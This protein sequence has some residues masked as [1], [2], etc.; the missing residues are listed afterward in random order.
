METSPETLDTFPNRIRPSLSG[1]MAQGL[2][3]IW[4]VGP[5]RYGGIIVGLM[6]VTAM[7]CPWLAPYDPLEQDIVH[8]FAGPSYT[9]WL[10]TDYLGRD[11]LS[12]LLYGCRIA[13]VVALGAS[14][15]SAVVGTL[16][17]VAA[18]YREGSKLDYCVIFI[19]D[20]IRSFPQIILALA[21]V[22]VMGSSLFNMIM[23]LGFTV[24]PFYGRI[25]RA[26][27]LSVK[28][29]DFIQAAEA[30][31]VG[32]LRII[33]RHI[34]PNILSPLLICMGM[35]MVNMII[36][37]SGLSFLGLGVIPPDASWGI[38]LSNGFKYI[39][40]SIWMILWPGAALALAMIGFSLFSEGMRTALDPKRRLRG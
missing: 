2:A 37:E 20:V 13:M 32:K 35:D 14:T 33:F 23:A 11:L 17:G 22:A 34:L 7:I 31:G 26:Q 9:H 40:T 39:G 27:T 5:G 10:G 16:L 38:M 12:R 18:G 15:L 25:A 36:Y 8:R 24:I 21:I 28:E 6:L 29:S 30:M 19:F 1:R 4:R 3:A